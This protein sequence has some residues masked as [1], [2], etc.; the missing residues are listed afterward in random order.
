MVTF[1]DITYP[2]LEAKFSIMKFPKEFRLSSF[3]YITNVEKYVES[4]LGYLKHHWGNVLFLPCLERLINL[5][6]KL[7]GLRDRSAHNLKEEI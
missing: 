5:K 2:E 3:E 7:D 6:D 4:H 1:K